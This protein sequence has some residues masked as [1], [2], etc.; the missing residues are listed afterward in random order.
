MTVKR[1]TDE[2]SPVAPSA[3]GSDGV[4]P[5][6]NDKQSKKIEIKALCTRK[7][8]Y[9]FLGME[10][11]YCVES[12]SADSDIEDSGE[13]SGFTSVEDQSSSWAVDTSEDETPS[14]LE[15]KESGE[16]GQVGAVGSEK[17][18]NE[19][20]TGAKVKRKTKHG[21]YRTEL[22]GEVDE[23]SEEI[24]LEEIFNTLIS[25]F[26][27]AC[28]QLKDEIFKTKDNASPSREQDRPVTVILC[29]YLDEQ[30]DRTF[31][32]YPEKE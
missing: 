4:A 8:F 30:D 22:I 21:K 28:A 29:K 16:S 31:V 13:M 20:A 15:R 18:T 2:T 19:E 32:F 17:K 11:K 23:L 27:D 25:M 10:L 3:E 6:F 1:D 14:E 5:V 9:K 7:G 24:S 26:N 12:D